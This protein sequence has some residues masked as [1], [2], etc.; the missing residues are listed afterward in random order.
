MSIIIQRIDVEW[1]KA[2]RGAPNSTLRNQVAEIYPIGPASL[3]GG[4]YFHSVQYRERNRFQLPTVAE[5][6]SINENNLRNNKLRI[7]VTARAAKI[8]SWGIPL[9]PDYPKEKRIGT[10]SQDSWLRIAGNARRSG[11]STWYYHKYIFNI[12][13][14]VSDFFD[15]IISGVPPVV[16]YRDEVN[17]W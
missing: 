5:I 13:F 7:E 14:G 4:I 3:D 11:E 2:S 17:L 9:R 15:K 1:S 8:F 6:V 12:F 16:N 10:L